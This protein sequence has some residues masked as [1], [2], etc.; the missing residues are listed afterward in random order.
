[1]QA[2]TACRVHA[3]LD[4]SSTTPSVCSSQHNTMTPLCQFDCIIH[5][6]NPM[7]QVDSSVMLK[8]SS[9]AHH[10]FHNRR[11]SS[12]RPEME[13]KYSHQRPLNTNWRLAPAHQCHLSQTRKFPTDSVPYQP[14]RPRSQW[15][16][17]RGT[18]G[19]GHSR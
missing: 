5:T 8:P 11:R 15:V 9:P 3:I 14:S 7:I 16:P 17:I 2:L 10:A 6:R 4:V 13:T 12:V 19:C 18:C 1:M